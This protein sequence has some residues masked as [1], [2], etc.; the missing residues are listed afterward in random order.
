V[1]ACKVNWLID[2]LYGKRLLS[3]ALRMLIGPESEKRP[4]QHSGGV[5]RR[6]HANR[7]AQEQ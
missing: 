4:E 7:C 3:V 6:Q 5:G 1:S 2:G